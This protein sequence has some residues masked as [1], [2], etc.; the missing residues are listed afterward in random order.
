MSFESELFAALNVAGVTAVVGE[1]FTPGKGEQDT[2]PPY[3]VWTRVFSAR[4]N[5]LD[6]FTSGLEKIRVQVD[7]YSKTFDEAAALAA[8]IKAAVDANNSA[9][10]KLLVVNEQNFFEEDTRLHRRMVELSC[11]HKS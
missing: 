10:L 4:E 7:C 11:T 3:A 8:A 6:G 1:N 9:T 5:S 2:E